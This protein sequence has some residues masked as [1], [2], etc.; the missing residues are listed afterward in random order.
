MEKEK[1]YILP[2]TIVKESQLL[3]LS[4]KYIKKIASKNSDSRSID[5]LELMSFLSRM[6][7][8][9]IVH[10][11]SYYTD[12]KRIGD[13]YLAGSKEAVSQK[14]DSDRAAYDLT[15]LIK[16]YRDAERTEDEELIESA[17]KRLD[18]AIDVFDGIDTRLY[19]LYNR[20]AKTI[21]IG[22]AIDVKDRVR[23][24]QTGSSDKLE[25]LYSCPG[26]ARWEKLLH[27]QIAKHMIKAEEWFSANEEV[28][29][30]I[31]WFRYIQ[32]NNLD[33]SL[34]T[35]RRYRDKQIYE[36][37]LNELFE[38]SYLYNV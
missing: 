19:F 35:I 9:C 11:A 20:R 2:G 7:E 18:E 29:K 14:K 16:R 24:L 1:T 34:V 21:K 37:E 8:P 5:I 28:F 13:V 25:V 33:P 31:L 10:D 23:A 27:K 3:E 26:R 22:R 36:T 32:E 17:R 12:E 15:I 6:K 38:K 30:S 4:N